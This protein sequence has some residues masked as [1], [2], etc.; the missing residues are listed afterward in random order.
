MI[1]V[2]DKETAI[3][4]Y[5]FFKS[6][7]GQAMLGQLVAGTAMPQ[8][9]TNEIKKLRIPLLSEDEKKQILLNFHNEVKMYNDITNIQSNIQSIH[10]SFL[11]SNL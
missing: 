5:M 6:D 2:Q 4:L 7:I 8:I 11:R 1:R 3:V 10:Q 9:S